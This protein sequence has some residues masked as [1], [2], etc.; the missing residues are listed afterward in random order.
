MWHEG[1]TPEYRGVYSPF[2][3]LVNEDY[4]NLGYTLLKM[5][6]RLDAGDI[7]VQGKAKDIDPLKDWH[8]YIGHKVIIDSLPEVKT[9]LNKLEN[10]NHLP[11]NRKDAKDGFY[12][13]P[14]LTAF[15]KFL[16]N[17]YRKRIKFL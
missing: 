12:S 3:A 5:N 10:N 9:L 16:I 8:G 1:I 4:D 6:E 11:I 2:W 14:T 7:F 17:R 15:I 13:Y